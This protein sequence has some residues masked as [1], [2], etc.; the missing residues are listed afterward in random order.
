[1]ADLNA[2]EKEQIRAIERW[3]AEPP[4]VLAQAAG[5]VLAPLAWLGRVLIPAQAVETALATGHAIARDTSGSRDILART[6]VERI[7]QLRGQDMPLCDMAADSVQNRAVGAAA[8]EGAAAGALGFVATPFDIPA[9]VVL[10]LRTIRRIGLCYGFEDATEAEERFALAVLSAAGANSVEDKRLAIAVL[11]SVAEWRGVAEMAA[12]RQ[13]SREATILGLRALA[14]QLS[15][16]LTRRRALGS[17]PVL[18]AATG[19][20]VSAA[21]LNDVAWAARR[22]YQER[23]LKAKLAA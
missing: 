6:G 1:M 8:A 2:Y 11:G 7:G 21:F 14:R 9:T 5:L 16:N 17:I 12:G 10:A 15:R 23:W 3:K 4:G 22:S 18:G 20:A 13:L 19:A